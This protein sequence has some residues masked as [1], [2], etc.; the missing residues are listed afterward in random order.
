MRQQSEHAVLIHFFQNHSPQNS[1]AKRP[2]NGTHFA[3]ASHPPQMGRGH[4]PAQGGRALWD[5]PGPAL[6]LA[7]PFPFKN[8]FVLEQPLLHR[9]TGTRDSALSTGNEAHRVP[10]ML[11]AGLRAA[12]YPSRPASKHRPQWG[13]NH[14]Q[15]TN[16]VLKHHNQIGFTGNKH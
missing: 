7:L 9:V 5:R 16:A 11:F 8:L 12:H 2:S 15:C 3:R 14:S 1:I 4:P 13:A 6:T 10:S